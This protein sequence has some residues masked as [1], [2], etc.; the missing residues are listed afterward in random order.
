MPFITHDKRKS[1]HIVNLFRIPF[2]H[3]DTNE[4]SIVV[5]RPHKIEI[6]PD[7]I[8]DDNLPTL[9]WM[10]IPERIVQANNIRPKGM[11]DHWLIILTEINKLYLIAHHEEGFKIL[12][13]LHFK[14]LANGGG[15]VH[16]SLDLENQLIVPL[17]VKPIIEVDSLSQR[18]ILI[19]S[20]EGFV[21]I[22]EL[23]PDKAALFQLALKN[24]PPEILRKR[25]IASKLSANRLLETPYILPIGPNPIHSIKFL[26]Y[27]KISKLQGGA[28]V[29]L[30]SRDSNLRYGLTYYGIT[31]LKDLQVDILKRYASMDDT[32]SLCIPLPKGDLLVLCDTTQYVY[33]SPSINQIT[34]SLVETSSQGAQ[35]VRISR[36]YACRSLVSMKEG[37]L[38]KLISYYMNEDGEILCCSD[39]GGLFKLNLIMNFTGLEEEETAVDL[40]IAERL[41]REAPPVVEM[42]IERWDSTK[43]RDVGTGWNFMLSLGKG[44]TFLASNVFN[45]ISIED[46]SSTLRTIDDEYLPV[47]CIS[48][49]TYSSSAFAIHSLSTFQKSPSSGVSKMLVKADHSQ[50]GEINVLLVDQQKINLETG[51]IDINCKLE[52]VNNDELDRISAQCD[53]GPGI[54]IY[55]VCSLNDCEFYF[56]DDLK[57]TDEIVDA[58]RLKLSDS[59]IIV[60][61][62]SDEQDETFDNPPKS[63]LTILTLGTDP[64]LSFHVDHI[65]TV[66]TS[67]NLV[68]MLNPKLIIL[69][70][71]KVI[72]WVNVS[73]YK[74]DEDGEYKFKFDF[75]GSSSSLDSI[76]DYPSCVKSINSTDVII[77]DA[78]N[79]LTY[80]KLDVNRHVV[81]K[82]K[83]LL[84]RIIISQFAIVGKD[85]LL[86][87]DML[88][89]IYLYQLNIKKIQ[90]KLILQLNLDSGIVNC[91][92]SNN[93]TMTMDQ[94]IR[95]PENV[96]ICTLGTNEGA[97]IDLIAIPS[98]ELTNSLIRIQSRLAI[99]NAV[100]ETPPE[101][102]AAIVDDEATCYLEKQFMR[103]LPSFGVPFI[104]GDDDEDE[105]E[106][107]DT[108][109]NTIIDLDYISTT[110]TIP[111]QQQAAQKAL[112]QVQ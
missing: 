62:S 101:S 58:A 35:G 24:T 11:T 3:N 112:T 97:L 96:K 4:H 34:S 94:L 50:L 111:E 49:K 7:V 36:N 18:Y 26:N 88:G 106:E 81:V 104:N 44:F 54:S 60:S 99:A 46:L 12:Q 30:V 22:L 85:G 15:D 110:A 103:Y 84:T 86:V 77:A 23:H 102:P 109:I 95:T 27:K 48:S 82:S 10:Y 73:L 83:K 72:I 5:V 93:L 105:D 90:L 19:H 13:I 20:V 55:D 79:G 64:K 25:K 74:S 70:G 1:Q 78:F 42:I 75:L 45:S 47:T 92:E 107:E 2:I 43:M 57:L 38:S 80:L 33:P 63:E 68:Y 56:K 40:S 28:L 61:S 69:V 67:I 71:P 66:T 53:F 31:R 8:S 41:S 32:P 98:S 59:F 21:I 100:E 37:T 108:N 16:P 39:N 17:S 87:T 65:S 9:K 91:I 14:D 52:V 89:N 29:A 6:K 51:S 76:G